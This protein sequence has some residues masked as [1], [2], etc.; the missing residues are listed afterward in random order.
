MKFFSLV[1]SLGLLAAASPMPS[2]DTT[3]VVVLDTDP[4]TS[5]LPLTVFALFQT[6]E[7]TVAGLTPTLRE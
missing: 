6:L 4:N 5:V 1:L 3:E 2:S 7:E